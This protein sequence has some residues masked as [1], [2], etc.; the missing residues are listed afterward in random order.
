MPIPEF[1]LG[2]DPELGIAINGRI[3]RASSL[4]QTWRSGR[5]EFGLDGC[6]SVAEI[7]PAPA[8]EP[9]DVVAN[10]KRCLEI[11]ATHLWPTQPRL[12][13]KAGSM[14]A[15]WPI[16]GHI[17]VGCGSITECR[18]LQGP[19]S[20]VFD[21]FLAPITLLLEDPREA[22]RRRTHGGYGRLGDHREQNWGMEYRTPGSWITSPAIAMGILSMVRILTHNFFEHG[23]SAEVIIS[24]APDAQKFAQRDVEYFMS[25]LPNIHT[26][27]QNMS[28]YQR[29][30]KEVEFLFALIDNN[31]SWFPS[32]HM[33]PAWGLVPPASP[34]APVEV[35]AEPAADVDIEEEGAAEPIRARPAARPAPAPA[36]ARPVALEPSHIPTRT[37]QSIWSNAATVTPAVPDGAPAV[38]VPAAVIPGDSTA[39]VVKRGRDGVE[40]LSIDGATYSNSPTYFTVDSNIALPEGTKKIIIHGAVGMGMYTTW[41]R[42]ANGSP[43]YFR[44]GDAGGFMLVSNAHGASRT[45]MTAALSQAMQMADECDVTDLHITHMEA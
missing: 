10:I 33:L 5:N 2:A 12:R 30:G 25:K 41:V 38:A 34:V 8:I 32:Q 45:S 23:M 6:T 14:A 29:Y 24:S 28:L 13:F 35:A 18:S 31:C 16:G 4:V 43:T 21:A 17:H 15:N 39:V 22:V 36:P 19:L 7:R 44:A 9:A 40:F 27:V 26:S 11:G 20:L 1:K 3:V 37:L 42:D